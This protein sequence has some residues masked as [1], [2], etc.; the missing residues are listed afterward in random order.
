MANDEPCGSE[1]LYHGSLVAF[2]GLD[3]TVSTQLRLLPSCPQIMILPSVVHYMPPP[4]DS[5]RPF[6]AG[7]YI[8]EVHDAAM[9]R[10]ETALHFLQQATPQ[11]K[12]LAFLCGGTAGAQAMCVA[13]IGEHETGGDLSKA[14]VIFGDLVKN[15]V[16]GLPTENAGTEAVSDGQIDDEEN[17]YH[18]ERQYSEKG[19]SREEDQYFQEDHRREGGRRHNGDQPRKKDQ[20]HEES[21][22]DEEDVEVEEDPI[23]RAMKAAD[24]LYEETSALQTPNYEVRLRGGG[25]PESS[26]RYCRS[27]AAG[28]RANARPSALFGADY[29]DEVSSLSSPSVEGRTAS[30]SLPTTRPRLVRRSNGEDLSIRIPSQEQ[31]SRG[32]SRNTRPYSPSSLSESPTPE[33]VVYGEARLIQVRSPVAQASSKESLAEKG[34]EATGDNNISGSSHANTPEPKPGPSR[35]PGRYRRPGGVKAASTAAAGVGAKQ[36][37]KSQPDTAKAQAQSRPGPQPRPQTQESE[38]ET[39]M[40]ADGHPAKHTLENALV[41]GDTVFQPVLPLVEDLV[42]QFTTEVPNGPLDYAIQLFK[43]GF[44]PIQAPPP[45]DLSESDESHPSPATPTIPGTRAAETTANEE[46]RIKS[47]SEVLTSPVYQDEYDPYAYHHPAPWLPVKPPKLPTPAQAPPPPPKPPSPPPAPPPPAALPARVPVNKFFTVPFT[48]EQPP[49]S[50]QNALRDVLSVHF[51]AED[52]GYHQ[53]QL[54]LITDSY[55][56][57]RPIFFDPDLGNSK[58][59]RGK[60]DLILALGAQTGVRKESLSRVTGQIERLATK[61]SGLSRG[62][63]VELRYRFHPYWEHEKEQAADNLHPGT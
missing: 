3:I 59:G 4:S 47:S 49:V 53:S 52:S 19:K 37:A 33:K 21:W 13:A 50:V 56:L 7:S 24:A 51:P 12:R 46:V 10:H 44:Y 29:D 60:M 2:E 40:K 22:S 55:N 28:N 27:G 36:T 30:D 48:Q 5:Q 43:E 25:K 32:D 63:R 16:A 62:L 42:I 17:E 1:P 54:P 23:I 15:G 35:T 6:N 38:E 58:E 39:D 45:L 31:A 34:E 9:S 57:W 61:S 14:D 8:R 20:P 41:N 26:S 18:E 11:S